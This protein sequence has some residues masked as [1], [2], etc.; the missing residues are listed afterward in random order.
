MHGGPGGE[1][2]NQRGR[3]LTVQPSTVSPLSLEDVGAR[4]HRSWPR[5]VG[6]RRGGS[7]PPRG[8]HQI[9]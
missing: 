5:A 3:L 7:R 6:P 1:N 2:N 8:P 9:G 4:N